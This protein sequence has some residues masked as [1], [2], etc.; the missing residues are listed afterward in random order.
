MFGT[1]IAVNKT[2]RD[3]P[4][5]LASAIGHVAQSVASQA[6]TMPEF[7][8]VEY[9]DAS[10]NCYPKMATSPVL[11][12][13]GQANKLWAFWNEAERSE[14]PRAAYLDSMIIGGSEVQVANTESRTRDDLTPL[15]IG[16]FCDRG[17]VSGVTKKLSLYK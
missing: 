16:A 7:R 14:S 13:T 1:I 5:L 9:L 11:V 2:Y 4:G 6:L 10:G 12:M 8:Q 15:V 17:L 3:Q